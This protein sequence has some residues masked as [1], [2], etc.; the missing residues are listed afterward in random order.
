VQGLDV[1]RVV[2]LSE[3]CLLVRFYVHYD[4]VEDPGIGRYTVTSGGQEMRP[5]PSSF[6]RQPQEG[7]VLPLRPLAGVGP[8]GQVI[9]KVDPVTSGSARMA[10]GTQR[11]DVGGC[12]PVHLHD[13]Q[14]E[15][16]FVHAGRGTVTIGD[17][18]A[19][20]EAGTTVFIPPGVWHGVE[21]DGDVPIHM[22][23]VVSPPGLEGMF[24]RV[25]AASDT[26]AAPLA[27]EEFVA[28]ARQ[29]GMR[30]QI[31]TARGS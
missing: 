4:D 2:D 26:E 18:R 13:Q 20:L 12:I 6:V 30:V 14:E 25:S 5:G 3:L 16:L 17:E 27:S 15:I 21:N 19:A 8:R 9:I 10:M 1:L 31:P 11:I 22:V 23:W 7:E 29:H 28:I 24:R